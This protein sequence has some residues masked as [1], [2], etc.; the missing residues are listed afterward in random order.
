GIPLKILV[1]DSLFYLMDANQRKI[2]FLRA[3]AITLG[4]KN[5]F[6]LEGRAEK[7]GQSAEYRESFDY[8]LIKAVSEMAVL[9]ELGLPLLKLGGQL[10]LYKG[11]RGKEEASAAI[12]A[13]NKCG[14]KLE[15]VWSY[16]LP[17]GESR[18]LYQ[19]LKIAP[20]PQQYPRADGK[21]AH[22]PL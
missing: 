13:I 2:E 10:L 18:S 16:C 15:N 4:L 1:E 3:T 6:T 12:N 9:A 19:L 17:T 7:W 8:V 11:P 20:T 21:P 5:L 22:K 14:G